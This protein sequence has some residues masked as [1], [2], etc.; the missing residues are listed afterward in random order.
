MVLGAGAGWSSAKIL[1]PSK[2]TATY[3]LSVEP[4]SHL[5]HTRTFIREPLE[6]T[7]GQVQP[8]KVARGA[9]VHDLHAA[10]GDAVGLD[11]DHFEALWAGVCMSALSPGIQDIVNLHPPPY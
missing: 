3:S 5:N 2:K 7:G 11:S 8:A 4:P 9:L 10:D 1:G 6:Q